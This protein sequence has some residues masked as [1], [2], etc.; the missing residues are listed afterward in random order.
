MRSA[1]AIT[2]ALLL[3]SGARSRAQDCPRAD[4]AGPLID[5]APQ[6]LQG[7]LRY[8]D[9][10]RQ[11]F[12][13]EVA[14]PICGKK[15]IELVDTDGAFAPTHA[16]GFAIARGCAV[17]VRGPLGIPGTG[18]Y[19]AELYM[20][21]KS[22]KLDNDCQPK[23]PF[24]DYS[25]ERIDPQL[26]LYRVI[27]H[28]D[29]RPGDHP[30]TAEIRTGQ[31]RLTPWQAYAS[32]YFTGGFV[33]YGYCHDGFDMSHIAG[34]RAGKPWLVDNYVA[35]DPE[36]AAVAG[37]HQLTLEYTCRRSRGRPGR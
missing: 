26:R 9:D 28:T 13:L 34:T 29:Y 14:R 2:V 31:R 36:S 11:W 8:H 21:V 5:S 4:P 20:D 27:M 37:V 15:I 10:L 24:P 7:T 19:S 33:L 23:P 17:T 35:F 1:V 22:L 6:T 16:K 32:Y 25:Q 3:L 12:A 18:Y 30:L